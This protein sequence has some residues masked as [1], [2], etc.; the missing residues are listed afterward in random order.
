[1]QKITPFLWFDTEAVDA[2]E[3]YVSLF[4]NSSITKVSRYPEGGP[5]P[6]GEPFGVEFVLDGGEF[7]AINAGPGHPF[8]D[9]I[10]LFVSVE[11]QE[12]VDRLWDGLI[13]GGGAPSRCGWLTDRWGL[14]WQIVP[15]IL[16]EVLTGPDPAGA[17]RAMQ[18]MMEMDK[19]D[20]AALRAAYDGD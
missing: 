18:A 20:I 17:S 5:R 6:A 9:A 13:A 2:A 7:R 1:M 3:Y 15:T 10:S 8:T 4:P 16:D 19:L 12:E 11:T 14:S